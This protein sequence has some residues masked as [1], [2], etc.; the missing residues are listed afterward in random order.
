MGIVIVTNAIHK[1]VY[2]PS[3]PCQ[4]PVVYPCLSYPSCASHT[5][6]WQSMVSKLEPFGQKVS[7]L[8]ND[9]PRH[10]YSILNTILCVISTE[11]NSVVA[12][13]SGDA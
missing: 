7:T 2:P 11:R 4:F 6:G 9:L 1:K 8:P 12:M 3:V 10:Y 5:L 13:P